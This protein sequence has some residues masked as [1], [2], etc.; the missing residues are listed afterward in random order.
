YLPFTT[1]GLGFGWTDL[2]EL[3]EI[4]RRFNFQ[5]QAGIGIRGPLSEKTA[6]TTEVRLLHISNAGAS[7]PN[8]GLN[9]RVG[10]G[11]RRFR[12]GA[13]PVR[14]VARTAASMWPPETTQT[15]VP[16]GARGDSAA[17]TE[18]APAPSATIRAREAR[19]RIAAAVSSRETTSEPART[20][21]TSGHISGRSPRPPIPSTKLGV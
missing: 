19:S 17:A 4:S 18:A 14:I 1:L 20:D 12:Y 5:V 10:T 11:R 9:T 7:Y 16:D 2:L 3:K 13:D 8:L 15:M 6:W 21:F